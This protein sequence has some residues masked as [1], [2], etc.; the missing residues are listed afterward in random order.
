MLSEIEFYALSGD[1]KLSEKLSI[2]FEHSCL[3]FWEATDLTALMLEMSRSLI[4]FVISLNTSGSSSSI[5]YF[6]SLGDPFP[7]SSSQLGKS[8][9]S[10]IKFSA[11]EP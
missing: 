11:G 3:F 1:R 6:Y 8:S 7:T 10:I 5:F 2:G 4:E 9:S